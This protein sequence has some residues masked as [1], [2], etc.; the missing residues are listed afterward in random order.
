[1]TRIRTKVSTATRA[2]P[3]Q[4]LAQFES[5]DERYFFGRE[6]E[7]EILIANLIVS[8][9][10]I[11][12]GPSG[13]G[14]SS[15]LSAGVQ[16]DLLQETKDAIAA[17][18]RAEHLIVLHA[19]PWHGD[20]VRAIDR[21][22]RDV[23]RDVHGV[24]LPLDDSLPLDKLLERWTDTLRVRLLIILDQFDEYLLYADT[25]PGSRLDRE[26][27]PAITRTDIDADFIISIR[28]D[29]LAGLDRFKTRIPH[30]LDTRVRINHLDQQAAARAI[31]E[32]VNRWNADFRAGRPPIV[33]EDA[34]IKTIL[35]QAR[36][37]EVVVGQQ[38]RG[39]RGHSGGI[40]TPYL[41]LVMERLW[42]TE[43]LDKVPPMLRRT[44]LENLGG[45]EQI[46]ITRGRDA[47]DKLPA[48]EQ[49]TMS[50]IFDRLVT[51]SGAKI[52]HTLD[53]LAQW[54][55][56]KPAVLRRILEKLCTGELRIL[57]PIPPL[58]GTR[59]GPRYELFH[60]V[61][62]NAILD[63]KASYEH[64]E[65]QK[66]LSQKLAKEAAERKRAEEQAR[67]EQENAQRADDNAR[68][69]AENA[70]RAERNAIRARRLSI[71][72]CAAATI[73][74]GLLVTGM[75]LWQET[76]KQ[77][78]SA[79]SFAL[80][81]AADKQLAAHP[82]TALLFSLE[83]Y[84]SRNS[85]DA[86]NSMIA[87]LV[88]SQS[89]GT[90]RYLH[91]HRGAVEN[92]ALSPD[93]RTLVSAGYDGTIRLW[94]TDS[95]RQLGEPLLSHNGPVIDVAFSPD[96][97]T[98]ASAGNDGTIA[99]WDARSHAPQCKLDA[100]RG[101]VRSV[102][103]TPD[104]RKLVS[105]HDH[106]AI[107][108]WNVRRCVS[109]GS[110]AT[111]SNLTTSVAVDRDGRTL[112][113]GGTGGTIQRWDL[114]RRTTVRQFFRGHRG[115]V[116][117]VVFSPNGRMLASA[118]DDGTIRLWD[119]RS[120]RQLGQ[121]LLRGN[122]AVYDVAFS[123]D[124]HTLVSAGEDG[125]VRLWDVRHH[126]SLGKLRGHVGKVYTVVLGR[127]GRVFSAGADETIRRWD[128]S[129]HKKQPRLLRGHHGLIWSVAFS[130]DGD[131]L[132]SAGQDGTIRIWDAQ[133]HTQLGQPLIGHRGV[134]YGVAFSPDGDTL[135]SAGADG[136]VQIWDV[137][138]QTKR[139]PALNADASR[140]VAFSP[141][142]HTLASAGKDGT[143][144]L[145][146]VLS[147]KQLGPSLRGD[148]RTV[149]S[150]AFSPDGRSFAA[151]GEDGKVRLWDQILW[152]DYHDVQQRACR[153]VGTGLSRAEWQRLVP[154]L[155]YHQS[156]P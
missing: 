102:A 129:G 79:R 108:I 134:V 22:I 8:R 153:L 131:T 115:L 23:A 16:H 5:D 28:E 99:L 3:F 1:M 128:R 47:I 110:V 11:V 9:L 18:K 97:G 45:V 15:L 2:S 36:A 120:R 49:R 87:S 95:G 17:G 26:L 132:A 7:R 154:D 74:V 35:D 44:T 57:R 71:V 40:E 117:S 70:L 78:A 24:N 39:T 76:R 58:P 50:A 148:R 116:E 147:E 41:Q 114:R 89:S 63:W 53:D 126:T 13:V 38:G 94:D 66:R 105:A 51:P 21:A 77:A 20:P 67:R 60:D 33:V 61:L 141:D 32:P 10:T 75:F 133:S 86:T 88:S 55:D 93:G 112:V 149:A 64:E 65:Q 137:L 155:T 56:E 82:D 81:S 37:G 140:S 144:H 139:E 122:G 150:V 119:A 113:A 146:D 156:C 68:A 142:G 124:G 103:F 145:W 151:A 123:S 104:G 92:I 91:G 98:V 12:Y 121:P 118:G 69:A 96:G 52:A 31:R 100:D 46:V 43:D 72:A 14:K 130:P 4:G 25:R 125:M 152:H 62:A 42:E 30:L 59:G 106:G 48:Q 85:L 73:A 135:A 138:S 107:T 109:V 90:T 27:P 84:R 29:A 34:L 80:V 54:A 127:D 111:G 136:T 19:G 6:A 101:S 143:V 83:A